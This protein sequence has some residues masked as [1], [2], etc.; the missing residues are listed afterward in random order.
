M[1]EAG[2]AE[3]DELGPQ[4]H[5]GLFAAI[6]AAMHSA[7]TVAPADEELVERL[8]KLALGARPG[9]VRGQIMLEAAE[10]L[11]SRAPA[12][13]DAEFLLQ[14]IDVYVATISAGN[15]AKVRAIAE[16]LASKPAD[17]GP[18]YWERPFGD[19]GDAIDFACGHC[20]PDEAIAFLED[21]RS[22]PHGSL[23]DAW[24]GYMRWLKVQQE[25]AKAATLSPPQATG[26]EK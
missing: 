6:Y 8:R 7:Q 13:E 16:R 10:R 5:K 3:C 9:D 15:R 22:A 24:P 11:A 25:G 23:A 19:A 26:S 14:L 4:M 1:I 18:K 21:W 2:R 17:D 12:D 20:A